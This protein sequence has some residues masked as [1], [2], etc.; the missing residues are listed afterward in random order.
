MPPSPYAMAP[1][2]PDAIDNADDSRVNTDLL[3]KNDEFSLISEVSMGLNDDIWQRNDNDTN[4]TPTLNSTPVV[5]GRE[6]ELELLED[7]L[8]RTCVG[9][10]ELV[11][12]HGHSG[13]GKSAI[14]ESLRAFMGGDSCN[15]DGASLDGESVKE[16]SQSTEFTANSSTDNLESSHILN[17][18]LMEE[19]IAKEG[20]AEEATMDEQAEEDKPF[21][22]VAGKFDQYLKREPFSAISAA[23]GELIDLLTQTDDVTKKTI[24]AALTAELTPEE[25]QLLSCFVSNLH[26]LVV[27]RTTSSAATANATDDVFVATRRQYRAFDGFQLLC[28]KF[29]RVLSQ[30]S[31]TICIFLDD[32][33]WADH[34]SLA[35]I[36][37][38]AQDASST[39]ILLVG[40][41]RDDDDV[42]EQLS[43]F[44]ETELAFPTLTLHLQN[45]PV[46]AVHEWLAN[47]LQFDGGDDEA[48]ATLIPLVD[49]AHTRTMGNPYH[50]QQFIQTLERDQLITHEEG[51]WTWDLERIQSETSVSENVA[52][53]I[54]DKITRL[55]AFVQGMLKLGACLGYQFDIDILKLVAMGSLPP[56]N[57]AKM[58]E[59]YST[60]IDQVVACG[61]KEGLIE[62]CKTTTDSRIEYK[63]THDRVQQALYGMF[64]AQE[65]PKLHLRVG[66][67]LQ[68]YLRDNELQDDAFVFLTVEQ[69]NRGLALTTLEYRVG[70][71]ELNLKASRMAMSKS[72]FETATDYIQIAAGLLQPHWETN[73]DL[74]LEVYTTAAQFNCS[75]GRFDESKTA[76]DA[77][78]EHAKSTLDKMQVYY[79]M[80]DA[81]GSQD[82]LSEALDLGVS[83]LNNELRVKSPRH[84]HAGQIVAELGRVV[85]LIGKKSDDDIVNAKPIEDETMKAAMRL[86]LAL[87]MIAF[88]AQENFNYPFLWIRATKLTLLHGQDRVTAPIFACYGAI[89]SIMGRYVESHRLGMLARQIVKKTGAWEDEAVTEVLINSFTSHWQL[90][91]SHQVEYYDRAYRAALSTGNTNFAVLAD[92]SKIESNFATGSNLNDLEKECARSC[93][94]L[95]ALNKRTLMKACLPIWQCVLNLQGKS[96]DPTILTGD[97]MNEDEIID[98][99]C[100]TGFDL[101]MSNAHQLKMTLSCLFQSWA[102]CA[103]AAK[104]MK[105]HPEIYLA[106]SAH[107][108][109]ISFTLF[110]GIAYFN[111]ARMSWRRQ[112]M[113]AAR[114]SLKRAA[115]W[116]A[117][118]CPDAVPV[119]A[120]LLAEYTV[121]QKNVPKIRAQYDDAIVK[122]KEAKQLHY[123]AFANER[124]GTVLMEMNEDAAAEP[125]LREA[126]SRYREWGAMAKV[127]QIEKELLA[128][129]FP[130]FETTSV[131]G[132]IPGAKQSSIGK[133]TK[134]SSHP[135]TNPSTKETNSTD[136]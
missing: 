97:A 77:V 84:A 35:V 60:R 66:K 96:E 107:Y 99:D 72:A 34:E 89:N 64:S 45:L 118:G 119:H 80:I 133:D 98:H 90:P 111:L 41:Y 62:T 124:C 70:I 87:S 71:A 15:D 130:S 30:F 32:L 76:S 63:F 125:Y 126:V 49:L 61:M 17:E 103:D 25:L 19:V 4:T 1:L 122:C 120:M 56:A 5:L 114:K 83:I 106:I 3:L 109:S 33:Q 78:L 18:N 48:I 42:S 10:S 54:L 73:Y 9:P 88:F 69:L 16:E 40:A 132:S 104:V 100:Q 26:H 57:R 81:L 39:N 58:E 115:K 85:H 101:A 94:L 105:S 51:K 27:P 112:N 21:Y 129:N 108:F 11:L 116:V 22:L 7:C 91:I 55:H 2:D 13:V 68:D 67:L 110:S 117:F 127:D 24:A 44:L 102:D 65:R 6:E 86:T 29:L 82:L 12:L 75:T 23:F 136:Q 43:K 123:L 14:V 8:Q 52:T 59:M 50:L 121:F 47:L 53:L 134:D 38:L 20:A 135:S 95:I 46:E 37:A 74:T 131:I 79:T 128:S 92:V 93:N 36:T 31:C 28:Q 113:I